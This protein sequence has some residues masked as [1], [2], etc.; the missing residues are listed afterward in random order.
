M[1]SA[2]YQQLCERSREVYLLR[3]AAA[4]L[5][6]DFETYIPSKAVPYRAEQ[7]S[8]LE[9]KAHT[10]FTDPVVGDWLQAAEQLG[11]DPGLEEGANIREWRRSYDRATKIPVAL[12]EEFEKTRTMAREAWA[13]ARAESNFS[14]FEPHVEKIVTLTR[15]KADLWGYRESPYD[16]LIEDYEPG[17]TA[18]QV[19][20]I[21]KE[22]R[23][24]LVDLLS[25]IET[26]TKS[27]PE[28]FLDGHYSIQGQQ[29]FSREVAGA[30]G[31]D[32]AAGR[33][34]TT[35]HPFATTLGPFDQ[36][37][38]TRYDLKRFEFSLYGVMHETG[39]ALY[40]Q[41]LPPDRAGLPSG[42]A[43]S[44]GIH[45][46]QSRL[47]ENHVGRTPEFWHLWHPT[48]CKYLP[49][50]TR[51]SPTDLASGAR[52][53]ALSFIRV[54]ADE[55][56]YDLHI[57]LRFEL[58][59]ALVEGRLKV[60]DLP[61]AWN[62]RFHELFGLVVPDDARGVL[63]DIHWSLGSLGYFPTYTLGNLNAAQLMA[64]AEKQVSGLSDQLAQGNYAPLLGWL[65]ENVH[66]H[67]RRYLP[68][69][70]MRRATGEST[71]ARYRIDY[72]RRKYLS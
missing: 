44:L 38:T 26:E 51:F 2:A 40:E 30:F 9:A 59:L 3:S 11:F 21:L 18:E 64:A 24:A 53:V 41:G 12:I 39:H 23:A 47:W 71:Q 34:D 42:E 57:L 52:R 4:V 56:T 50:L 65:R 55:V 25:E 62:T 22:L 19:K 48:A 27:L 69:D 70:L 49:D 67:G 16:A 8:Y 33:I 20:P 14:L 54:E 7:L 32:F 72:L 46:S 6:W 17:T 68:A 29:A 15:Q 10:L 28:N 37:I 1:S 61:E 66:Q 43:V 5:S 31:Y 36:R 35:M 60:K 58:E 13:R 63:Q 45:E